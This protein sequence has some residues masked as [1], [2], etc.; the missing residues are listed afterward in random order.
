MLPKIG[1]V[2]LNWQG[3]R[4]TLDCLASVQGGDYPLTQLDI[5]VVDNGSQ[6][7]SV[8]QLRQHRTGATLLELPNNVG[9]AAGSNFGIQHSLV[10]GCDY[11]LLLNND[12]IASPD[13][14]RPLL[15]VFDRD[16]ASG[17]VS[18]KI[19]YH[20]PSDQI[21]YAGGRFRQPRLIG[22]MIGLGES[23]EGQFD[24]ARVVDFAVGCCMLIHRAVFERIGY[25]DERF[26]F[27]QE[28]VDFSYRATKAGFSV[29]YQPASVIYHK[30]SQSTR[31]DAGRRTFLYAQSRVIFFNKH[32]RGGR[33][34]AVVGLEVLRL[35][36]T[37]INNLWNGRSHLTRSYVRG[38]R[39][40]LRKSRH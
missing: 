13:F 29:W 19:R 25:L 32:I 33:R 8:S 39:A 11:V 17:I 34:P 20:D 18:P 30:V 28:D 21:W 15:R 38:I 7:D 36:R 37:A 35:V 3:W 14:L 27:Y 12:A 23:D 1:I 22:E 6:D 5:V 24:Q 26:F 2:I 9:F 40:G 4:D 31:D 16:P 10:T